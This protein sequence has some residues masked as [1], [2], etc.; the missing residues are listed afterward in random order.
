MNSSGASHAR[1]RR[2]QSSSRHERPSNVAIS[3]GRSQNSRTYE[4]SSALPPLGSS[5]RVTRPEL[6]WEAPPPG[7]FHATPGRYPVP[8]SRTEESRIF[9]RVGIP[10]WLSSQRWWDGT[11]PSSSDSMMSEIRLGSPCRSHGVRGGSDP[12]VPGHA[13]GRLRPPPR[14]PARPSARLDPVR[15]K[16]PRSQGS[17]CPSGP[18]R[19][20]FFSVGMGVAALL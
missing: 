12:S 20:V 11:A 19:L 9:I 13:R 18:V 17:S 14:A 10:R 16:S 15:H 5:M 3:A 4:S 2:S 8:C 6:K 1:A 7:H